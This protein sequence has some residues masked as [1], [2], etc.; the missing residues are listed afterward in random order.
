MPG[1]NKQAK[2]V[3]PEHKNWHHVQSVPCEPEMNQEKTVH[4]FNTF[5]FTLLF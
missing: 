3:Y 2:P 1:K 4:Q 5:I